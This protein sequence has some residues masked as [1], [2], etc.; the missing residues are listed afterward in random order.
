MKKRL[1][2]LTALLATLLAVVALPGAPAQ[3]APKAHTAHRVVV[4]IFENKPYDHVMGSAEAPYFNGLT[5]SG[6]LFSNYSA[7]A[8]GSPHDYRAITSGLTTKASTGNI[9]HAIDNSGGRLEWVQLNESLK[10]TCGDGPTA[11]VPGTK[12]PLF[13][14]GHDYAYFNKAN[15]SCE[16][17]DIP[18]TNASFDPGKLPDLTFIVP[19]MCSIMHTFPKGGSC[20]TFFGDLKAKSALAMGD[21]WLKHVLPLLLNQPDITV[22][23]TFDEGAQST[24]EHVFT[25]VVGAGVA[26]GG[27]DT[28][29]YNHYG[30]CAG[31]YKFLA[32]GAAPNNCAHATPLP[33]G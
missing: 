33:I 15:E 4:I 23:V 8:P 31:L 1:G 30:L 19:N 2:S 22:V 32:L 12:V 24:H 6:T 25:V 5:H 9:F 29:A 11:M 7:V 26:A 28:R 14:L 10:G 13:F 27:R 18:L 21:A 3:S 16:Q 17:H 20:P